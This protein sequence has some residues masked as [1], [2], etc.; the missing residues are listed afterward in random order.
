M[1]EVN[2]GEIK[3]NIF[4]ECSYIGYISKSK[5]GPL[6]QYD[7]IVSSSYGWDYM[8]DTAQY[9]SE[10][11]LDI[12][13]GKGTITVSP[14]A[15]S[16]INK[17]I[18][19]EYYETGNVK[20]L[21]GIKCEQGVL[22]IGGMSN[23]FKSPL[24]V[25]WYNQTNMMRVF[26]VV[27]DEAVM[28]RYIET[29]IRRKFATFDEMKYYKPIS[30]DLNEVGRLFGFTVNEESKEDK[31]SENEFNHSGSENKN[32]EASLTTSQS[33]EDDDNLI[34]KNI[35]FKKPFPINISFAVMIT[36]GVLFVLLND[37]ITGR[38]DIKRDIIFVIMIL[39]LLIIIII[40]V[41]KYLKSEGK[42]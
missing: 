29:I 28:K 33:D 5:P 40:N 38:M 10:K 7:V 12:S 15:G 9:L 30:D 1:S 35:G 13:E 8:V 20:E 6:Y 42:R 2:N 11:E 36:S 4:E 22:G 19:G 16:S 34:R 27:D 14:F 41:K 37:L 3:K 25:Y 18:I 23:I 32:T 39:I 17:E 24:K 26:S 21:P 31:T